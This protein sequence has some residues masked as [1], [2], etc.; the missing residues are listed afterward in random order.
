V[1]KK[2]RSTKKKTIHEVMFLCQENNPAEM[3][4]GL[5]SSNGG[6]TEGSDQEHHQRM[7]AA[8]KD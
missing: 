1:E 6:S 3:V 5:I 2:T 7:A 8:S 4:S